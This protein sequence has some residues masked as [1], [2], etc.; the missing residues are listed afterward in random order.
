FIFIAPP[1]LV[2][3]ERR[4]IGRQTEEASTIALRLRNASTELQS[5][6]QYDYLIVNN[7]LE[8]ARAML[9]S[10]IL[11]KRAFARRGYDGRMLDLSLLK[12]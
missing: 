8:Q 6:D 9:T 12:D 2:E 3:L 11:E 1:S 4:L 5:A 10:I 7:D